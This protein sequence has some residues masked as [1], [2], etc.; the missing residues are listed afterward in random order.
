MGLVERIK[1]LASKKGTN[2]KN[3]EIASDLGN[4][5]IRRWNSVSPSVEN[6]SK[7]AN[8][9]NVSLDF[10]ANGV[11]ITAILSDD[12]REWLDLIHSL[13]PETQRDFKGAMR[14]HKELHGVG[15]NDSGNQPNEMRQ[16]K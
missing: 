15:A 14:L 4:G 9:L 7:V 1:E 5:T 2:L 12:D 6:L 16:A 11:E 8:I 13:P 3:L 10:L